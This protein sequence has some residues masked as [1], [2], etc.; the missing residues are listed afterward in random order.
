[1]ESTKNISIDKN[2]IQSSMAPNFIH[3]LD[4]SHAAF[5]ITNF[6]QTKSEQE[7]NSIASI[8]DSFATHATHID[9]LHKIIRQT[10]FNIYSENQLLKFKNQIEERYSVV[11]PEVPPLGKLD[12]SS[13]L[14]SKY[15]FY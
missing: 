6:F 14:N 13:V 3:S 15:L 5:I 9:E 2:Q 12:I 8:H 10:F 7:S 1:M 4:A 11:V